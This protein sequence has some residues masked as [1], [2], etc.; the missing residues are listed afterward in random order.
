MKTLDNIIIMLIIITK[1]SRIEGH[2]TIKHV[3]W[4]ETDVFFGALMFRAVCSLLYPS[5]AL[6]VLLRHMIWSLDS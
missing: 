1:V 4:S 3:T 5:G 2:V 6:G